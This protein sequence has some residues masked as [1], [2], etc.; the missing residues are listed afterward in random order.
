MKKLSYLLILCIL[1]SSCTSQKNTEDF[2]NATSGRYL[3]N[4][5]EVLEIYFEE[6]EMHAKWRGNDNI[7]LLKVSD[8]SFYM[9]ELN[10]KM[11]F[12]SNPTMHIELA[13]KTEHDG[14][15]YRFD[16]MAKGEKTP[17]EYFKAKEYE[18]A[19]TGYLNIQLKDSL[20]PT[21]KERTLN[22]LGYNYLRNKEYDNAIEI[23]NINKALYPKS[24]NV[25]D[26]LGDGYLAKKDTTNAIVYYQKTL[27][28]NP[29]N[30]NAKKA[31]K[32]LT[33]E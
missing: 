22:K 29:E 10:E 20:N 19:L 5:N 21:I 2:I 9:K 16:K 30:S 8:S 17:D 26:A 15:I 13:P 7:E 4:A 25:Y 27:A 11:I 24:S 31:Y 14:I 1:I 6:A 3:F 28:I 12:V 33:A 32:K 23:F 18:K